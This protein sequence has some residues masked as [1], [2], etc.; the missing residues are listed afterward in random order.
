MTGEELSTNLRGNAVFQLS[1]SSKELFH[2]N[3]LCW[4]ADSQ[5]ALF[6]DIL[7]NCFKIGGF[8]YDPTTMVA[9]REYKNFDFCICKRLQNDVN[10]DSEDREE[11]QTEKNEIKCGKVLLVLE[12][13]FKSL[14]YDAQLE[15]YEQKVLLHNNGKKPTKRKK[16]SDSDFQQ[17]SDAYLANLNNVHFILLSLIEDIT[18]L[19]PQNGFVRNRWKHVTYC[20]YAADIENALHRV[21]DGFAKELIKNYQSFI[22]SFSKYTIDNIPV[23]IIKSEWNILSTNST[24]KCLRT[25]DIWQKLIASKICSTIGYTFAYNDK[26][27]VQK[28]TLG[29]VYTDAGFSNGTGIVNVRLKISETCFFMIQIQGNQYRRVLWAAEK[30]NSDNPNEKKVLQVNLSTQKN[31]SDKRLTNSLQQSKPCH[32]E[33]ILLGAWP[34]TARPLGLCKSLDGKL[35]R[36]HDVPEDFIWPAFVQPNAPI[37]PDIRNDATKRGFNKYGTNFVYQ[38]YKIEDVPIQKVFEAIKADIEY[39]KKDLKC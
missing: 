25:D 24:M 28:A 16:E 15:E 19:N 34:N 6:N 33:D 1:L 7:K 12:N 32:L 21:V 13:K 37:Y 31:Q 14:P 11:G 35:F 9:L 26:E 3:F 5:T 10:E 30:S 8:Q 4:L 29:E 17:R 22:S 27:V 39:V 2:S 20:S 23:D 38:Y 18:Y 36:Y